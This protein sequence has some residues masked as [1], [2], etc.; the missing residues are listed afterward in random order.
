MTF[1]TTYMIIKRYFLS[2]DKLYFSSD[3]IDT[4]MGGTRIQL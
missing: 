3:E 4:K 1:Y 2:L